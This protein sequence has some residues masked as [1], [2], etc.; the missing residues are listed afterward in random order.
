MMADRVEHDA[1][2]SER[3]THC[4]RYDAPQTG[5]IAMAFCGRHVDVRREAAMYGARPTC[6]TCAR[7]LD[8]FEAMMF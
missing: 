7:L 1:A 5:R 4:V 6:E 8:K 2:E 3:L